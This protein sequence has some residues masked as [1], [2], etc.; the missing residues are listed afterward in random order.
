VSIASYFHTRVHYF[1]PCWL[2]VRWSF[3]L[4]ENQI[5]KLLTAQHSGSC[6]TRQPSGLQQ[7]Q[8]HNVSTVRIWF[9]SWFGTDFKINK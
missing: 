3:G 6:Q 2:W 5:Q 7:N 9:H 8:T 4:D 1:L